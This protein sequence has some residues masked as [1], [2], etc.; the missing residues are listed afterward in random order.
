MTENEFD[1]VFIGEYDG[2]IQPDETEVS[3]YSFAGMNEIKADLSERPG[4]YTGWFQIA[5]PK[6]DTWWNQERSK[7]NQQ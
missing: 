1:H 3:D 5:F 4:M 2:N 6:I 7:S